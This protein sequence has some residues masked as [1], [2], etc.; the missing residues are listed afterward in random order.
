MGA[1][2][3]GI[4]V[5]TGLLPH[6]KNLYLVDLANHMLANQ[7]DFTSSNTYMKLFEN[8]GVKQ[9]YNMGIKEFHIN[10]TGE[11][12]QVLLQDGTSIC[13]DMV[14]N[15]AGV[16]ANIGFLKKHGYPS[17]SFWIDY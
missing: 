14:I 17:G 4:D 9:F 7:L 11:C 8:H 12:D 3:I 16:R 10:D 13:V 1:G 6:H 5:L 15:C 2:L